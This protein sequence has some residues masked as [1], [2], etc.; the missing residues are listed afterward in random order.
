MD[1]RIESIQ[2][3][4]LLDSLTVDEIRDCLSSGRMRVAT[5]NKGQVIHLESDICDKLEIILSGKIAVERIDQSGNLFTISVFQKEDILGGNLLFSQTPYY[6]MTVT[7]QSES[8]V[9]EVTKELL[10]DLCLKH[11]AVLEQFLIY[12]S[13]HTLL[14]GEKIKQNVQRTIRESIVSFLKHETQKQNSQTITLPVSKKALAERFGVQRT[15]LSRELQKMRD[16]KLIDF[17]RDT[18]EVIDRKILN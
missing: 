4:R 12:I 18:I 2:K 13:D 6:P 9:L 5:Y 17:S 1:K 15:S 3:T 14:L 11:R 16:E 10:F 8:R 7:A